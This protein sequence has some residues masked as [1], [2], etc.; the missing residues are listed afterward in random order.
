MHLSH[1]Q[2]LD[3]DTLTS[4]FAPIEA[5]KGKGV[6]GVSCLTKPAPPSNSQ[7]I[8]AKTYDQLNGK[9]KL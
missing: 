3:A 2:T 4:T 9:H 8:I 6:E 5:S 1:E 7:S